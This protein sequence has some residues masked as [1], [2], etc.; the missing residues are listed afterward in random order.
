MPPRDPWGVPLGVGTEGFCHQGLPE[1]HFTPIG[2]SKR[3]L[4]ACC[5]VSK[6]EWAVDA[7][8]VM[9]IWGLCGVKGGNSQKRGEDVNQ[10][11]LTLRVLPHVG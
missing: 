7:C 10:F 5:G 11:E 3:C 6:C 8:G 9:L 1:T 2:G 4:R